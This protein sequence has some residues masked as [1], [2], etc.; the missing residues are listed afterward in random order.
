MAMALPRQRALAPLQS[1][2]ATADR[3]RAAPLLHEI[4]DLARRARID[5]EGSAGAA[6]EIAERLGLTA[7]ELDV[8]H[9]LADGRTNAQIGAALFI[10]PK[11]A[12]VHVSNILR[13]V[14]ATNPAE[15]GS[16]AYQHG[17]VAT[18]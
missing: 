11:T 13:K 17:L 10:S 5:L 1:A 15:A 9:L 18:P 14:G 12:S 3:L 6:D 7:R 2:R 8:L 4:D 16:I